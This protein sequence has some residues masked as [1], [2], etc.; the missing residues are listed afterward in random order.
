RLH[1]AREWDMLVRTDEVF[2]NVS[3]RFIEAL[4][5]GGWWNI[6]VWLGLFALGLGVSGMAV[7]SPARLRLPREAIHLMLFG[8]VA[9][10]AGT[11]GYF[12]FLGI[13]GYPT[14][15]W[16]YLALLAFGAVLLDLI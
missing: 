4:A 7:F 11:A 10:V 5:G 2:T 14:Q 1:S 3:A 12:A 15:A 8:G 6:P 16:Y 9:L 13:V